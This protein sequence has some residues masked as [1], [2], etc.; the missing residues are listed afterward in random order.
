MNDEFGENLSSPD[1]WYLVGEGGA[2]IVFK[3]VGKIS[4]FVSLNLL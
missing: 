1:D 2:T 4:G 3:Y